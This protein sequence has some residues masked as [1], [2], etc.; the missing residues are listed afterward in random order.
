MVGDGNEH[1]VTIFSSLQKAAAWRLGLA[2]LR[3]F[4]TPGQAKAVK[5]PSSRLGLAWPIWAWPGPAH[6]LR[7]GQAQHYI[8]HTKMVKKTR[9][10][11]EESIKG[12]LW[13][14][15]FFL[16]MSAMLKQILNLVQRPLEVLTNGLSFKVKVVIRG[17]L[18]S[19]PQSCLYQ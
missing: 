6:G 1:V 13:Q 14:V 7:P 5:K 18:P 2:W 17:Y 3:L 19:T 12:I 11:I 4:K 15:F 8:K 16:R 9:W 10:K